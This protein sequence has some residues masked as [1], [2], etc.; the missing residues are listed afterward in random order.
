MKR[1]ALFI[2]LG[3]V[4][5]AP[6]AAAIYTATPAVPATGRFITR[7]IVWNCGAA[8]CQGAS[9]ESRPVVLCESLAKRAGRIDRFIVDGRAFGPAELERCNASAKPQPGQPLA[10]K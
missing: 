9:E 6:A 3:F 8:A 5:T 1:S 10:S 7:D 2:L 4:V